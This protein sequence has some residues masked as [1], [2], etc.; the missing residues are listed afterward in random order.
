MHS[1]LLGQAIVGVGIPILAT[2]R[3]E[4]MSRKRFLWLVQHN[5]G[6]VQGRGKLVVAWHML[7]TLPFMYLSPLVVVGL[8]LYVLLALP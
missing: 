4:S 5:N 7:C 3:W 8:Q 6:G 2:L 1:L